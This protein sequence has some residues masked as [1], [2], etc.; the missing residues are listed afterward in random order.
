MFVILLVRNNV[1]YVILRT[2][3]T[4]TPSTPVEPWIPDGGQNEYIAVSSFSSP[5]AII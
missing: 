1:M 4:G 2:Y 3:Y 5:C